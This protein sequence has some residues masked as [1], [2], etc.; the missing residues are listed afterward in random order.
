MSFSSTVQRWTHT[1]RRRG[2][3]V[4]GAHPTLFFPLFRPRTAF[5]DL[6][7]TRS[8]DICIEG[9]PRSANS[10]SVQAFRYAQSRPVE[11]AHHTHVPAN[12]M[13]ACEWAIPTV[14]LIRS[15]YDA[16]VS[17]IALGKEVQVA[18]R[19]SEDP[20]QHVRFA[21][22]LHAWTS[23][24]RALVRY[25]E[26]GELLVA[27]FSAVIQDMG[28]VIECVNDHFGTDF[29]PFD[30][31]DEAVAA[32]RENQGYHAGPNARRDQY[33]E[34][35]RADFDDALRSNAALQRQMTQADQLFNEYTEGA[36]IEMSHS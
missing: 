2:K 27:P 1:I 31:T 9:F 14:I 25:R 30:H 11:V 15:P 21:A 5:D 32:V 34:E 26:H 22:W 23:F 20:R 29:V 7:V 24:Y 3:S 13:R 8:T 16:I 35:T 4:V 10:F 6:L 18:E 17:R 19:D 28:I 33:K 12:A 36:V